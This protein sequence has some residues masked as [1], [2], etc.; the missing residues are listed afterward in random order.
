MKITNEEFIKKLYELKPMESIYQDN[1]SF[2]M[3]VPGGWI[4]GDLQ[5]TIFI[6]FNNEFMK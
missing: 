3:R 2:W 4:Y 1:N 5:G 6:P